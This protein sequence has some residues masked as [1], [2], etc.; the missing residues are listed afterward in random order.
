MGE[1]YGI[2]LPIVKGKGGYFTKKSTRDLLRS[3]VRMIIRTRR[4]ERVMRP[5]IGCE[6][7]KLA[8][9]PRDSFLKATLDHYIKLG[10]LEHLPRVTVLFTRNDV[11][12]DQLSIKIF[13]YD[14]VSKD[15]DSIDLQLG[16]TF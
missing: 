15:E 8:F 16:R 14:E 4:G 1:I 9:D 13:F 10:L 6:V 3:G 11:G 5:E 12:T 7:P 2:G